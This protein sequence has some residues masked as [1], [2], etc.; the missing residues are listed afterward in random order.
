MDLVNFLNSWAT[1]SSRHTAIS[2]TRHTTIRSTTRRLVYFH[3]DWIHD[4]LKL[5]LFCLELI[6]LGQLILIEPIKGFL[7]SFLN[8]VFVVASNLSLSFSSCNVLRMVK[9]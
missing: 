8:L 6:L 1:S 5:L 2:T 3:H 4:T 9:Q 7:N